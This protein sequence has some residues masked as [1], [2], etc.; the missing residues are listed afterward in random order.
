M[1]IRWQGLTDIFCGLEWY[2]LIDVVDHYDY[3]KCRCLIRH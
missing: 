1:G 2:Y 3:F